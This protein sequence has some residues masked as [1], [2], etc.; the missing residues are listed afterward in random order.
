MPDERT[1]FHYIRDGFE[2]SRD[3]TCVVMS[4]LGYL[5]CIDCD[6]WLTNLA[7]MTLQNMIDTV[8]GANNFV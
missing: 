1:Q 8:E 3:Q 7:K 2:S 5:T 4:E 6:E